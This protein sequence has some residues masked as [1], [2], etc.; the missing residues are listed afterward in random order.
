MLIMGVVSKEVEISPLPKEKSA[1][2]DE[3]GTY[4]LSTAKNGCRR[5]GGMDTEREVRSGDDLIPYVSI[6]PST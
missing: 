3:K 5:G 6:L 1:D 2:F 4:D